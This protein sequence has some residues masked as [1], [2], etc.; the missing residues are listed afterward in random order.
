V[1]ASLWIVK[2]RH[3]E[4]VRPMIIVSIIFLAEFMLGVANVLS[5]MPLWTN[6]LHNLLAVGL[7]FAMINL[8]RQVHFGDNK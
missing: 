4:L 7:L 5:D 1:M 6:T 3:A 2:R 8:T